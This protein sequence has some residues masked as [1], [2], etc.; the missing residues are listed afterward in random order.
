MSLRAA[1]S[2]V[3]LAAL[4]VPARAADDAA[5]K[6]KYDNP[7]CQ[8]VAGVTPA[9][10]GPGYQLALFT[11]RG[12]TIDA[13]VTLVSAT[14]AFDAHVAGMPLSGS[15]GDRQ[16]EPMLLTVPSSDPPRYFFVDSYAIDGAAAVTCPSYVFEVAEE[17]VALSDRGARIHARIFSPSVR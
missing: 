10:E 3:A 8:V 9:S 4:A 15:P 11:S 5:L 1:A 12:A 7:F 13:H 16:T 6:W 14:D 17:T 2:L